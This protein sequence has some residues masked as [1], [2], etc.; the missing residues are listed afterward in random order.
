VDDGKGKF[1]NVHGF[2]EDSLSLDG[3][4][5]AQSGVTYSFRYRVRNVY[6]WSEFSPVTRILA[7]DVPETP[8][9]PTFINATDNSI[10]I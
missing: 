6:G 1:R 10:S 4:V 3:L 7:A 8:K 5:Q 9:R 2:D